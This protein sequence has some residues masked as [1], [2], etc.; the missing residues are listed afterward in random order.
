LTSVGLLSLAIFLPAAPPSGRL[1]RGDEFTYVGS[2]TETVDR[3]GMRFKRAHGLEV[4][5][6]VM[7]RRD[8]WSDA[9][10]LT[11]LRRTDDGPV[12]GALPDISGSKVSQAGP[13]AVRLDLIR[14]HDDGRVHLLAPLGPAPLR[15]ANDTPMRALPVLPLDGFAPFEFGM[16]PPR[17]KGPETKWSVAS[18]DPARPPESWSI[19]GHDF[20]QSERCTQLIGI[21]QSLDWEKPR[22]G[23]TSWQR[24]EEVWTSEHGLARRV[25]RTIVQRDGIATEPAVRIEVKYD[26]QEQGRPIGRTYDRYRS[27]I[28]A[29]HLASAEL[30]PLL[31]DAARRGPEPFRQRIAR[32]DDHLSATEPGTPYRE[33]VLAVRRQLE[34]ARKGEAIPIP[35]SAAPMAPSKRCKV[36]EEAPGFQSGDFRL[37]DVRDKPIVLVFFMPGQVTTE[38]AITIADAIQKKCGPR[39]AVVTLA[40][41]RKVEEGIHDRDR[42]KLTV[43]VYDGSPAVGAYGIDTFPRFL[44]IDT[45]GK[46]KWTFAGVGNET[47][48]LVKEQVEGLLAS[49][50][51]TGSPGGPSKPGPRARQ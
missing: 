47:G 25:H 24:T 29:A 14:I 48:F 41:F 17:Q 51:A 6:F 27:D 35:T 23:L 49:P 40:V 4:R 44:V 18:T 46:L 36:G 34:A 28:E 30:L 32:L 2:V 38:P 33:A 3:P 16:F 5:V 20:I 31:K 8:S 1:E 39:I 50:V 12:T 26:L 15:F 19:N 11:Q 43:P 37:S 13:P 7:E 42:L 9:A 21:Q 45:Q 10:V 22:G